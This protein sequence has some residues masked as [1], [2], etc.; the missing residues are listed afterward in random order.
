MAS[1]P[2][3]LRAGLQATTRHMRER[4]VAHAEQHIEGEQDALELVGL[5]DALVSQADALAAQLRGL[6]ELENLRRVASL[7]N[8]VA[9]SLGEYFGGMYTADQFHDLVFDLARAQRGALSEAGYGVG[10]DGRLVEP[11]GSEGNSGSGEFTDQSEH[12]TAD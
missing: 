9:H 7:A 4:L 8:K 1:D 6:R 11:V 2:S 3:K 12:A 10:E 5:A